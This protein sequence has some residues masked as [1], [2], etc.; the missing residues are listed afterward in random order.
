MRSL[1]AGDAGAR[2]LA[3]SSSFLPPLISP[4]PP[5]SAA[6]Q[7]P[8]G[9][10][11]GGL[12]PTRLLG[13]GC[14]GQPRPEAVLPGG[15]MGSVRRRRQGVAATASGR[16]GQELR[17]RSLWRQRATSGGAAQVR[18]G[19]ATIWAR[20]ALVGLASASSLQVGCDGEPSPGC[21]SDGTRLWPLA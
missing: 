13:E 19:R 20:R 21:I 3:A 14:A 5:A 18:A 1:P 8:R 6:G 9:A 7:S 10:G 12:S 2:T 4:P 11:D 16:G 15:S 17:G